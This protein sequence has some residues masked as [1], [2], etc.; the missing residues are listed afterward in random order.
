MLQAIILIL[1]CQLAGEVTVLLLGLPF[2]GPVLGMLLMFVGLLIRGETPPALKAFSDSLLRYLALLF[3]PAGVGLMVH[4]GLV[5]RDWL[6][7][8][9]ALVASTA[10]AMMVTMVVLS[11]LIR[12][13]ERRHGR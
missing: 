11:A 2:P 3:V 8:L 9:A 13:R 6:P 1:L 7:I 4:F 10:L 5:A 12:L